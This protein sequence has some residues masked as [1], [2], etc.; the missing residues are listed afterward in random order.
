MH[1][2]GTAP[3]RITELIGNLLDN[4]IGKCPSEDGRVRSQI[5][6]SASPLVGICV[7]SSTTQAPILAGVTNAR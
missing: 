6:A 4:L 3:K 5:V 7:L 1:L 2:V